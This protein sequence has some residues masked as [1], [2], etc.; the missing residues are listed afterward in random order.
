MTGIGERLRWRLAYLLNRLPNQCWA[1]LVTWALGWREGNR[2]PLPWR[3][4]SEACCKD[5]AANGSACYC[6]K[7]QAPDSSPDC[8]DW[9]VEELR[10]IG[11][12]M[13]AAKAER[14][15][16]AGDDRH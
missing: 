3:P 14:S 8:P 12:D 13:D 5:F 2:N 7:L 9:T 4:I 10:A 6:G 16:G 11:A 15:D 1:D